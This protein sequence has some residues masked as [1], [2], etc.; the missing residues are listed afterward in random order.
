MTAVVFREDRRL[1]GRSGKPRCKLLK[2]INGQVADSTRWQT[3]E[4]TPE[5]VIAFLAQ[6]LPRRDLISSVSTYLL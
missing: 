3:T 4:P 6:P 1:N 5:E 2:L